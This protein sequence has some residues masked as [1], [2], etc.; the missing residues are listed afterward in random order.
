MSCVV[1]FRESGATI[2]TSSTIWCLIVV[3]ELSH[4]YWTIVWTSQKWICNI[5]IRRILMIKEGESLL[6]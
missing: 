4:E 3:P 2:L 5:L 1:S 6:E